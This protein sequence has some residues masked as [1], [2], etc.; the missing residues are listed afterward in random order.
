[1]V[2]TPSNKT[3]EAVNFILAE[4]KDKPGA[5]LA[6]LIDEAGMRFNLTPLDTEALTRILKDETKNS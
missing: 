1:M 5:S 6:S 2:T 3:R 4:L